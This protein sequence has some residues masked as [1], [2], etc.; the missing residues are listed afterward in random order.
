MLKNVR[1]NNK[2]D[3]N[4]ACEKDFIKLKLLLTQAPLLAHASEMFKEENI[5]IV[6]TDASKIAIAGCLCV[7][8]P[9]KTIRPIEYFSKL[10]NSYERSY[11]IFELETLARI[12][13]LN[14][15]FKY[16][17]DGVKNSTC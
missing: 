16:Q 10:T 2:F 4:D 14:K 6:F 1:R 13:C 9:D 15:Q 7:L 11:S 5:S 12:Y 17:L 8:Y 3:W